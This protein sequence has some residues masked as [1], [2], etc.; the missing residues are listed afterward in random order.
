MTHHHTPSDK[1]PKAAELCRHQ[2]G[3]EHKARHRTECMQI[4]KGI[5]I[6]LLFVFLPIQSAHGQ[7][8][9]E[10]LF[11]IYPIIESNVRFWEEIYS[12]YTSRQGVLH[13]KDDLTLVYSVV[14]LVDWNTPGAGRIN[15]NLIKL[16]RH[17]LKNILT[18]LGHG[19]KPKTEEERKIAALFAK[20]KHPLYLK[21][22]D[23]IRLQIGQKD[24][25]LEGVIRSGRYMD[26]IRTIFRAHKMPVELAYLPHVESSFNQEAHSKAGAVGLWQFTRGTGKYYMTIDDVLDERY[27][28]L[29]ASHAAAKLLKENHSQLGSWPLA[30][31]AYNYGRAGMVRALKEQKSY[32]NIFTNHKTKLFQFASR[33]FY[34]EFV[35]ALRVARKL[36]KNQSIIRDRPAANIRLRMEGYANAEKIRRYFQVA[37]ED[38]NRLNPALRKP[39]LNGSKHIPKG[40]LLNLP[41]TDLTRQRIAKMGSQF[42]HPH[43]LRDHYYVVKR[44]DTIG[45]I[46]HRYGI[47]TKR[48]IQANKLDRRATIRVGQKIRLPGRKTAQTQK[49]DIKVLQDTVKRKPS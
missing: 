36:E 1:S 11:P 16:A 25:F 17:R 24:R 47:P 27:D 13:D 2:P 41:A 35:A 31:T 8:K 10:V 6:V 30:L 37:K 9:K 39:V 33:N 5:L 44:G 46:A 49:K 14:D 3:Q 18:K 34:S 22:K 40:Y 26:D 19:H 32:E 23:N 29:L 48:L 7:E 38:F 4:L 45:T 15:K 12:T 21:A 28:P 20:T 42:Y 43:Q